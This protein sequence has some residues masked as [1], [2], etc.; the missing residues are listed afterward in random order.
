MLISRRSGP[1][2]NAPGEVAWGVGGDSCG[3]A[4]PYDSDLLRWMSRKLEFFDQAF[5]EGK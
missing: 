5:L 2:Q 4:L 1:K 3:T